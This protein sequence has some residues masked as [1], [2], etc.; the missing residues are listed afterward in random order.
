MVEAAR[1]IR[2]GELGR[3]HRA[4]VI[5]SYPKRA[6]YYADTPWRGTW[7]GEGGGVLLNQGLH[8]IDLLVHL[9]GRPARVAASL[10]TIVQPIEAEDAADLLLEWEG[11]A[12]ASVHVTSAAPPDA[13]R[14]G[15]PRLGRCRCA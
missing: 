1:L 5:A 3:I 7:L 14:L 9:L 15:D 10:R 2:E 11:G 8:D 13:D 6:V 4:E 12:T